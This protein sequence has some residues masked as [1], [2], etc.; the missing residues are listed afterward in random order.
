MKT[1]IKIISGILLIFI[2]MSCTG[3][4]SS[5]FIFPLKVGNYWSYENE[6][7]YTN[8]EPDSLAD[9]LSDMTYNSYE[10]IVRTE[11]LFDTL[12]TYVIN[13]VEN[14]NKLD[15]EDYY[16]NENDGFYRYAYESISL[17]D[18]TS[19]NNYKFLYKGKY[20]NNVNEIILFLKNKIRLSS[21]EEKPFYEDPP[22]REIQYPVTVGSQWNFYDNEYM[23]MD[24]RVVGLETI[25]TIAGTFNCFKIEVL[26]DPG[27]DGYWD[28]DMQTFLYFSSIGWTKGSSF[29]EHIEIYNAEYFEFL[30]YADILVEWELTSYNVK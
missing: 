30:G 13:T 20:F 15:F 6:I 2:I 24:R 12:E 7:K 26:W 1:F 22:A 27:N 11:I 14:V 9:Y 5:D 21:N 10:E 29:I 25:E 8:F 18:K 4:S 19:G 23:R 17:K 16:R 3:D 28:E